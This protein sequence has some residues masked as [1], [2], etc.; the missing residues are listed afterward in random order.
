M[1]MQKINVTVILGAAAAAITMI[2]LVTA[3]LVANQTVPNAGAVRSIAVNVYWDAGC[4][5]TTSSIDWGYVAPGESKNFT[6]YVKN[7]GS[8]SEVLSMTTGNWSSS[9][10]QSKIGVSWN[11][12]GYALARGTVVS[13]V[14]TLS[15][16]QTISDV[17]G[18]SFDMTIIGTQS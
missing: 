17:T 15:V 16:D 10:A 13:A 5:N 1:A 18:F 4:T 9:S 8:T 6:I 3:S 7:P 12:G 11:R 2:A 14:L